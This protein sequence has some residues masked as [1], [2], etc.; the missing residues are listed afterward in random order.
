MAIELGSKEIVDTYLEEA[1]LPGF[2]Q[3]FFPPRFFRTSK[4]EIHVERD[5]EEVAVPVRS[6]AAS[7]HMN[8]A[9]QFSAKE[10][11]PPIY[12]EA[13]QV[14]GDRFLER[15]DFGTHVYQNPMW[16]AG[17]MADSKRAYAKLVKKAH[18]AFELQCSQVLQTGTL[19]LKDESDATVFTLDYLP[20]STHFADATVDWGTGT[21][22]KIQQIS[23]FA[24]VIRNDG[25]RDPKDLIMGS[26]A[27][28]L[29]QADTAV[30]AL[31]DNRRM[32]LGQINPKLSESGAVKRASIFIGDYE[33]NIWTYSGT[34]KHPNTG[35][36]TRYVNTNSVIF[37]PENPRLGMHF[38]AWPRLTPMRSEV[39]AWLPSRM[40]S[41][42]RGIAIDSYGWFNE[43]GTAL[44]LE[45]ATR[46]VAVPVAIDTFGC[47]LAIG[48]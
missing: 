48:A 44:T 38:G 30:Q 4:V 7:P 2:L 16:V 13:T 5:T 34:Y 35:A 21:E 3:R 1:P 10:L 11:E 37:L 25:K 20:K 23:D 27:W 24:D 8:E 45:A 9:N 46:A 26:N 28:N 17:A 22:D 33:L 31:L 6:V 15:R 19:D 40:T 39:S 41:T 12:K 32:E 42:E 29:F 43:D 47:M 14:T 36:V 18:R